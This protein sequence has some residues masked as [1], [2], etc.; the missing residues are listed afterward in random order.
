MAV[1]VLSAKTGTTFL[2]QIATNVRKTATNAPA[3][4]F[5]QTVNGV[6]MVLCV[7]LHAKTRAPIV[8]A[9]QNALN[10]SLDD[11]EMSVNR[12]VR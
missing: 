8:L 10:V 2:K 12:S 9:H 6:N 7:N 5:V 4:P 11:T 3:H 1:G